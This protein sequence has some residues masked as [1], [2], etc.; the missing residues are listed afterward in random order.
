VQVYRA[1]LAG[2]T[3]FAHSLQCVLCCGMLLDRWAISS[4]GEPCGMGAW[5]RVL[6]VPALPGVAH[7]Q[8]RQEYSGGDTVGPEAAVGW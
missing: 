3:H 2:L 7:A 4:V 8:G 1:M 6:P 5:C